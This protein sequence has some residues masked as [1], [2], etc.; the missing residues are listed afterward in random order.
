M[1]VIK[2]GQ[3][4]ALPAGKMKEV[5]AEGHNLLVAN[6][7]GMYYAIGNV[8]THMGCHLSQGRIDGQNVICPCHG[9]TFD[10]KT[11]QLVKGPA[12]KPEP[13]YPVKIEDGELL[14]VV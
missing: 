11:G 1:A 14:I 5:E 12:R 2:I 8:C 9:S 7:G 13:S 6:L 4:T 3:A 10:L